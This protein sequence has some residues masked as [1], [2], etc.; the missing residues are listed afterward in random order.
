MRAATALVASGLI[1]VLPRA[2]ASRGSLN[3]YCS[4]QI[5]RCG[6]V[7]ASSTRDTGVE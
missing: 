5:E 4:V 7:A 2:S 6:P 3:L 1:A